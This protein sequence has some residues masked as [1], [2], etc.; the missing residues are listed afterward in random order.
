MAAS[1]GKRNKKSV[2]PLLKKLQSVALNFYCTDHW[3]AFAEVLPRE[4]HIG[5]KYTKK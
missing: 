4:K 1:W 3:R 5:K 2:R